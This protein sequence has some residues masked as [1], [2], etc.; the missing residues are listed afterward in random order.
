MEEPIQG[1]LSETA[2]ASAPQNELMNF[3]R[4]ATGLLGPRSTSFL[5]E[6][7]L[8]ELANLDRLP[9]PNSSDWR[10]VSLAASTKLAT[11]LIALQLKTIVSK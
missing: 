1:S 8:E 4:N 10:M 7:W 3:I 2:R 6:L 5:T 11:R 9:E